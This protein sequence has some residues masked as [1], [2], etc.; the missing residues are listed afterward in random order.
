ME[1]KELRDLLWE[2]CNKKD[3]QLFKQLVITH[4]SSNNFI[5]YNYIISKTMYHRIDKEERRYGEKDY[6]EIKTPLIVLAT[7]TGFVDGVI[8]LLDKGANIDATD[9]NGDDSVQIAARNGYIEII[10]KIVK[11]GPRI[12]SVWKSVVNSAR[13][14]HIE[15]LK[16]LIEF[17]NTNSEFKEFSIGG[18]RVETKTE[19]LTYALKEC[20][21]WVESRFELI[22]FKRGTS[23]EK[24]R[25]E[26]KL[27]KIVEILFNLG[28]EIT[29]ETLEKII[30]EAR[31]YSLFYSLEKQFIQIH[32]FIT[33]NKKEFFQL[34]SR[35][36]GLYNFFE[37]NYGLITLEDLDKYKFVSGAITFNNLSIIEKF[38]KQY[39]NFD[40]NYSP[41]LLTSLLSRA[42]ILGLIDIVNLLIKLGADVNKIDGSGYTPI[43]H[44]SRLYSGSINANHYNVVDILISHGAKIDGAVNMLKGYADRKKLRDFLI[45]K[46]N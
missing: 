42:S 46:I 30:A 5:D 7:E 27:F 34:T 8:F 29:L 37:S 33:L 14:G 39:K 16:L 36:L 44:I 40:I 43:E 26:E 4:C 41:W 11:H 22:E 1:K 32:N 3:L 2:S 38:L 23:E 12:E 17:L 45:S 20:F 24:T 13:E 18:N 19:L 6:Y 9:E 31:L 21:W 28:A 15:I 25:E 10:K 35:Y